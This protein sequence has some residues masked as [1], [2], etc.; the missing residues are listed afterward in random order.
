[1]P[2]PQDY[3]RV[4]LVWPGKK[5]QVERVKLPFQVI[6]R[7][8]DVR[9]SERG[10]GHLL[11]T[12]L[13]LE[14]PDGWRNKLIWG[15]NRYVLSS[16]MEDF[17]G[18]VNLIYID[19]PF[20]TGA[21]FSYEVTVDGTS[22]TKEPSTIEMKAYRDTWGQG[23]GSYLEWL[24]E[25]L[26]QLRELL[27]PSGSIFVH[28][29][30]K[31]ASY[32]RVMLDSIFGEDN[33]LNDIVWHFENKPQFSFMKHFPRDYERILWYAKS[34]GEHTHHHEY[35]PVK[36]VQKQAKVAWDPVLKKRIAARDDE[37]KIIYEERLEKMLGSVWVMPFIHP[38]AHE[39]T[40]FATQK[41][42]AL[43]ERAIRASSREGDLVLDC[44]CGSGTTVAVA[45]RLGR[46]WIACDLGRF[47]VQTT[48]KRLLDLRAR[49]FEVLNLGRYER[50]HWQGVTA[51][52]AIGEYFRFIIE[53]F[54]GEVMP[55]FANLHGIKAGH[56]LHVGATDAPV[57]E[58]EL[59]GALEECKANGFTDLDVLGWEWEM[60][61]NREGGEHLAREYGIRL[62]L[63]NIPREVMDKR[64]VDAGDVH[65]FE[66]SVADL[67]P[68]VSGREA[69]IE[70][71]GFLPAIDDYMRKKLGEADLKW[72]DWIDYWS[73]DFEY[74]G[75]T[76]INQWQAYR[77]RKNR[78]LV[79]RSDPHTYD[80]PGEYTVVVKVIDIFGN[81]TTQQLQV[82]VT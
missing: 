67:Q 36:A 26:M 81:D 32:T 42:E 27:S 68:Q 57:T 75:E 64:A 72:S 28:L 33:F 31:M 82:T 34:F 7:V 9:R 22:F 6:E 40:G 29:N 70:L 1:M 43:L 41:P 77:T 56:L 2:E 15:D 45:E 65:F 53:L 38:L 25:T 17:A 23:M 63:F 47:A 11:G 12:E 4:E 19:P 66:L 50:K 14:W 76:F 46:R 48:R 54:H 35:V 18:K 79:L 30:Q 8:N 37:G 44:F 80:K 74:D 10:Q 55:G 60:G 73:I 59:R 62:R 58:P 71:C 51:G 5:T 78:T 52:E 49:P 61:L 21:D 24:S 20:D 3:K 16:L 13:P 69:V 39:R